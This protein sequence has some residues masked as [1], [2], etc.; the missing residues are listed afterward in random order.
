[1]L[2]VPSPFGGDGVSIDWTAKNSKFALRRAE[3]CIR[4]ATLEEEMN[5]HILGVAY[6]PEEST[7]RIENRAVLM[8]GWTEREI[9]EY[10]EVLKCDLSTRGEPMKFTVQKRRV[11]KEG[12]REITFDLRNLMQQLGEVET[13]IEE[14]SRPVPEEKKD[15]KYK[16]GFAFW[17]GLLDPPGPRRGAEIHVH[18]SIE[19][20]APM[21][22][23]VVQAQNAETKLPT[24]EN[25][26][27]QWPTIF[28]DDAKDLQTAYATL[29]ALAAMAMSMGIPVGPEP[30]PSLAGVVPPREPSTEAP[31]AAPTAGIDQATPLLTP[32]EE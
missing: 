14:E 20:E 23:G 32:T 24:D 18:D 21:V 3:W 30:E 11:P 29:D 15:K 26:Q 8:M 10:E 12:D 6:I 17:D 28:E 13:H 25:G 19:V 27:I 5:Q 31:E 22:N 1:M 4:I 2:C 7:A 9:H 16:V